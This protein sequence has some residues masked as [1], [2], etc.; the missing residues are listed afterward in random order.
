MNNDSTDSTFEWGLQ[1]SSTLEMISPTWGGK[2]LNLKKEETKMAQVQ[3]HPSLLPDLKALAG[4]GV[5]DEFADIQG[6]PEELKNALKEQVATENREKYARMAKNLLQILRA[7]DDTKRELVEELRA[8][9]AKERELLAKIGDLESA[10]TQAKETSN[11]LPLALML[12][13]SLRPFVTEAEL[14]TAKAFVA[15]KAAAAKR[16]VKSTK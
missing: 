2:K 3:I 13:P 15:P 9:R 1:N 7:S 8:T 11:Y 5:Q 10:T 12:D 6:V 14:A 16:V 4:A